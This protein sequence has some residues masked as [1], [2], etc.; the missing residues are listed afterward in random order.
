MEKQ[1][2]FEKKGYKGYII[3]N[4]PEKLNSLTM[5]MYREIGLILDQ[6]ENDPEI[7]VVI[8]KGNGRCFSAGYDLSQEAPNPDFDAFE[9]RR[10]TELSNANR[11]KIWRSNKPFIAQVNKYCL[12]GA[13]ELILPC[14]FILGDDE[15]VIGEP[16][17]QFGTYPGLLMIPWVCGL[18]QAK[19]LLL[20]GSKITGKKAAEIGLISR[21]YPA[22]K[23]EEEVEKLA[24]ELIRLPQNAIALQKRGINRAFD[25]MGIRQACESWEDLTMLYHFTETE[26]TRKFNE[27]VDAEGVKAALAW[28]EK[29]FSE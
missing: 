10:E 6:I 7:R 29:Y 22:D 9:D 17:I 1:V 14:D 20:L 13:C 19:E 23:L 25:I 2:L 24:D 18:R 3:L 28:R 16:E 11:W 12:G 27:I 21:S 26:E 4:R 8:M 15:L 5:D